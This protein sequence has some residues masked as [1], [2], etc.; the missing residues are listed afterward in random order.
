M[1][2][3]FLL[4]Q[5]FHLNRKSFYQ[6]N[7]FPLTYTDQKRGIQI[8]ARMDQLNQ[9]FP[10]ILNGQNFD[11]LPF[12]LSGTIELNQKKLLDGRM[13]WSAEALRKLKLENVGHSTVTS[14][15]LS[16]INCSTSKELNEVIETIIPYI[17]PSG[18][19]SLTLNRLPPKLLIESEVLDKLVQKSQNLQS[20]SIENMDQTS[21]Q[22]QT[23]LVEMTKNLLQAG[24][25]LK[26][27]TLQNFAN[28]EE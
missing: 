25:P 12:Y 17:A 20:L 6:K 27:L 5:V 11:D 23:K 9:N 16:G 19:Q 8:E 1:F 28:N 22:I 7:L 21:Y 4:T 2:L 18:L 26:S 3:N 10:L 14:I 15:S 24:T 13:L